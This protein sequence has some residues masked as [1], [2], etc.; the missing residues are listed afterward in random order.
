[1]ALYDSP[2]DRSPDAGRPLPSTRLSL[3]LA[4]VAAIIVVLGI[5][6]ITSLVGSDANDL[7]SVAQS[8][9][10]PPASNR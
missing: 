9:T 6:S 3:L 10:P 8:I 7:A 5:Y 2:H 1:M 4:A